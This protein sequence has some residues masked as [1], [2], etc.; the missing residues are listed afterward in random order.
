MEK[1]KLYDTTLRDGMQAEGVS[2]SLQDK[3]AIATCLDDLGLD[4]IEGGYAASNPKEMQFFSEAAKLGLKNSY[5]DFSC[6]GWRF[7][8]LDG[9]DISTHGWPEENEN[10]RRAKA[11]LEA[12]PDAA[13]YN[14]AISEAQITWLRERLK[15]SGQAGEKV[16]VFCHHPV[17]EKASQ[18]S[19]LLWNHRDIVALLEKYPCVAAYVSGHDHS[20]GY[21]FHGGIHYITL[22][23][24]VESPASGNA[25]GILDVY[26]DR[27]VL[28]GVGTVENAVFELEAQ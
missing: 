18:K 4:Y 21:A 19:L 10:Y 6:S 17:F 2:F 23:G 28:N 1:V 9:M 13:S 5:Y 26:K 22:Q 15:C 27:I 12:N 8:V 20:G 25:Y 16:I 7:I 11:Y 24:M 3:L 14:G